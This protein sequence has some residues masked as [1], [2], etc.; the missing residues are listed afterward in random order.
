LNICNFN[1]CNRF[2]ERYFVF[3]LRCKCKRDDKAD[4]SLAHVLLYKT[5]ILLKFGV[6]GKAQGHSDA[7]NGR[8]SN[9]KCGSGHSNNYCA[10]YKIAYNAE[11]YWTKLVQD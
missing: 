6:E 8:P 11:Y 4:Y 7:I 9:D 1:I 3:T 2:I 5:S 10:G